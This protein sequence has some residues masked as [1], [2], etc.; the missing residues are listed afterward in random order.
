MGKQGGH[1]ETCCLVCLLGWVASS[2]CGL[3][4]QGMSSTLGLQL[5]SMGIFCNNSFCCY[6]WSTPPS[7][8]ELCLFSTNPVTSTSRAGEALKVEGGLGLAALFACTTSAC[9]FE[10]LGRNV[11]CGCCNTDGGCLGPSLQCLPAFLGR[12]SSAESNRTQNA[13]ERKRE[14]KLK[15]SELFPCLEPGSPKV[16]PIV[17]AQGCFCRR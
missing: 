4:T 12:R 15:A 2:L 7:P 16:E 17:A 8:A 9:S 13:W 3:H 14:T 10:G 6:L 11:A 1:L 5:L